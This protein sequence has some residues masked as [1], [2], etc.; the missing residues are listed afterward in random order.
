[1]RLN[2]NRLFSFLLTITFIMTA[3]QDAA[4]LDIG[5][6]VDA[7]LKNDPILQEKRLSIDK[8]ILKKNALRNAAILPKLEAS[9]GVGPAPTYSA[10]QDA[11]GLFTEEY[12]FT[13]IKPLF[14]TEVALAQPLNIRRLRKGLEAAEDNVGIT[15][16][17]VRKTELELSRN[18]QE[19]C[20]QYFYAVRMKQLSC[21]AKK[22]LEKAI[23]KIATA[24]SEDDPN[25]SQDDLF[26]LKTYLFKADNVLSRAD[27]G[28][29]AAA[30][31]IRFSTG[32]ATLVVTDSLLSIRPE[33]IPSFDTLL[34]LQNDHDPDLQKLTISLKA[35]TALAELAKC[36]MF[37]DAYIAGNCKISRTLHDG[38]DERTGLSRLLDPF[39]N[40]DA[41]LG[42]GLRF[43]LNVWSTRD[44][45]LK[46]KLDLEELCSKEKY[47]QRGLALQ[48]KNH[49]RDAL[50]YRAQ[51]ISAGSAL[52]TAE[53]WLSGALMKYDLDPSS[54]Y[55]L[56]KAYEKYIQAN[57][58]YYDCVRDYNIA[59]AE[60]ISATGLTL[61]EYRTLTSSPS[62]AKDDR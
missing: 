27:R 59:V 32:A 57:K 39:D 43:S 35:R 12:D 42:I 51:S 61:N 29:E 33:R 16:Y 60:V 7:G 9:F 54:A 40:T 31:A 23:A 2:G 11:S 53:S 44:N 14:G 6:I 17:D 36:E 50:A 41:M 52:R 26:E 22:N 13:A 37:P 18:L 56:L 3:Y 47:A 1:M 55:G 48:L 49:Y 4:A 25:V 38:K 34:Q 24:L 8:A 62:T 20:Y 28:I 21:E 46:A 15:Y 45:Y 19:L 58:D 30:C 5:A 10:I